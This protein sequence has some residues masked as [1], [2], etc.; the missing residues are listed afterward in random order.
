MDGIR[1]RARRKHM[2]CVL[3]WENLFLKR[4][5]GMM[6]SIIFAPNVANDSYVRKEKRVNFGLMNQRIYRA[7][8]MIVIHPM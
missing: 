5:F 3:K 8:A 1:A 2:E 7:S 4:K 6:E